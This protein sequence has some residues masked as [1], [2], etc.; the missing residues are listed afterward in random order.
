MQE[1]DRREPPNAGAERELLETFLDY[2]RGTLLVKCAGLDEEQLSTRACEPS[3]LT[4]LGLVRHM[5]NV[6][7]NWFQWRFLGRD[8]DF[9]YRASATVTASS[10]IS[11]ARRVT[12]SSATSLRSA[13]NQE[14][15]VQPTT[16]TSSNGARMTSGGSTFAGSTCT[17]SR[18]TRATADTPTCCA[19]VIDGA[20]GD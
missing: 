12:T 20:T 15:L 16:S 6:E 10:T 8:V 11:T 7:Q 1:P 18:S 17:L 2:Y 14:R 9:V 3:T 5:T 19:N 13:N 4:L